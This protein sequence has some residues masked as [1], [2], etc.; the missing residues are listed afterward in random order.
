MLITFTRLDR[1]KANAT[2]ERSDGVV[3]ELTGAGVKYRVPH[4]MAHAVTERELGMSRGIFGSMAAGALFTSCRVLCGRQR[5]DAAARSRRIIKANT[6]EIGFSE[7]LGGAVHRVVEGEFKGDIGAQVR[8][9]W[10]TLS[11]EPCPYTDVQLIQAVS[12]LEQLGREWVDTAPGGHLHIPWPDRLTS[13]VP[14]APRSARAETHR[15]G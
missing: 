5:Y 15:R 11:A 2:I 14:P 3:V 1:R 8:S 12:T 7:L 4:D 10:G 13:P 9:Q 6:G